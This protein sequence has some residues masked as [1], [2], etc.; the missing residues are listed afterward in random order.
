M[1]KRAKKAKPE[2]PSTLNPQQREAV[3]TTKGPVLV[4]AGAGTGKTRTVTERMAYLLRSG[5]QPENIL[6]VTFTNKA[7]GEMKERLAKMVGK[8]YNLKQLIASTFHSLC[9]RILRRDSE[10]IGYGK[11]FSIADYSEQVGIIRKAMRY[12]RGGVASKPEDILYSIGQLKN[13]GIQYQQFQRTARDEE[14]QTL[15]AIYRRYQESLK[16]INAFDF[17]DLLLKTVDILDKH[18]SARDHWAGRFEYIMVDEFQDTNTIQ[19]RMV[20]L[21]ASAHNN[22]CV[23]GDDDQSIYAWRGAVADNILKFDKRFHGAKVIR[24]EENYR[25]VNSVLKAA[26]ALIANNEN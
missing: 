1:N 4:L 7:A 9:V 17:D 2:I 26:N 21:L 22:L 15:A 8:K 23:V 19:L 24:L 12:I 20:E 10:L 14:E 3:L 16:T 25:S 11:H 6:A 18:E 5:V 13:Q